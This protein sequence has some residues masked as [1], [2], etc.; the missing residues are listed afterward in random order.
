MD[1]T[2]YGEIIGILRGLTIRLSD[3]LPKQDLTWTTEFLDAGELGLALDQIAYALSEDGLPVTPDKR[4]DMLAL[5]DRMQ[6]D[7]HVSRALT[8]C[9]ER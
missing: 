4:A 1:A 8:F 6:M 2:H 7:D 3:R 9:P 5:A